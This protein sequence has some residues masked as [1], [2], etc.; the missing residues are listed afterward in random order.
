[1]KT[2]TV[3]FIVF[4]AIYNNRYEQ[5]SRAAGWTELTA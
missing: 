2:F 4:A 1:M 3:T 5:D